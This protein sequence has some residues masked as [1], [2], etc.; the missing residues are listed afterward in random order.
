MKGTSHAYS[1]LAG[2]NPDSSY[3]PDHAVALS[4][5]RTKLLAH[6]AEHLTEAWRIISRS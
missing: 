2:R 5:G 3:H 4:T 1:S 6:S